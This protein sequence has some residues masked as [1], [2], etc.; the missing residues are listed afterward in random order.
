MIAQYLVSES[1][2]RPASPLSCSASCPASADPLPEILELETTVMRRFAKI[3]QSRRRPLLGRF[4]PEEG[5]SLCDYKSFPINRL[6]HYTGHQPCYLSCSVSRYP[7]DSTPSCS[8][9]ATE[10][11][12]PGEQK[13]LSGEIIPVHQHR[14]APAPAPGTCRRNEKWRDKGVVQR[15]CKNIYFIYSAL[16]GYLN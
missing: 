7:A 6:Q 15:I 14:P 1:C 3:S 12:S 5:P 9:P 8:L 2:R 13:L 4:Q 11:R 16:H 10:S